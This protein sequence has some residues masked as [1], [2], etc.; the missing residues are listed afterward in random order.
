M[1]KPELV[2]TRRILAW[3]IVLTTLLKIVDS[4][5]PEN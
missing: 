2:G 3:T 1:M 5:A 4:F